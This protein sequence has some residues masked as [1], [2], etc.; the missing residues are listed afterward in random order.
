M[1]VVGASR[2]PGGVG[3]LIFRHILASDFTGTVYPVNHQAASV[4]GVRAY[5]SVAEVPEKPDLVVVAVPAAKVVQVVE[6][7]LRAGAGGLVVV[8]SGFAE[9]GPDGAA[10]QARL[11]DVVRSQ[12]A[13]LVGPNC[14]GLLN[15]DPEISLNASLA[16]TLPPRVPPI[17]ERRA[18]LDRPLSLRLR[19]RL[20]GAAQDRGVAQDGQPIG[21]L[22]A[23][24]S[25]IV[26]PR[27]L[28]LLR[29]VRPQEA[30]D[31]AD[32]TPASS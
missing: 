25:V 12:G 30:G 27:S 23:G 1:A 16:P 5:P 20:R 7:A 22:A 24:E 19:R 8:T 11:V 15:T 4:H 10:L 31:T 32:E 3:H 28:V 9:A 21:P 17:R 26:G 13:R 6:E 2:E 14:L 29:A 18:N